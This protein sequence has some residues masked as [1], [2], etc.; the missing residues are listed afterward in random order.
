MSEYSDE[1]A[2]CVDDINTACYNDGVREFLR[3]YDKFP[4]RN[5]ADFLGVSFPNTFS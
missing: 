2:D 5:W 1:I 3:K 4:T